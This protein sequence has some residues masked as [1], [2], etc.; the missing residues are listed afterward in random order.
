MQAP[1]RPVIRQRRLDQARPQLF[2]L[3]FLLLLAP[4]AAPYQHTHAPR[5]CAGGARAA[6]ELRLDACIEEALACVAVQ[7]EKFRILI[8]FCIS[9]LVLRCF[10]VF[11]ACVLVAPEARFDACV[12]EALACVALQR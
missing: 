4:R 7:R 10:R 8:L 3:L 6:P 9:V 5:R 1:A 11:S 2:K 12:E